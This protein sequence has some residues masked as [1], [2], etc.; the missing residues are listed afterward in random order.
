MEKYGIVNN[1]FK[2]E[3]EAGELAEACASVRENAFLCG[4]PPV[5]LPKQLKED[6]LSEM[7]DVLIMIERLQYGFGIDDNKLQQMVDKKVEKHRNR[8]DDVNNDGHLK[9]G[10]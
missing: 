2:M 4:E 5:P 6:L 1:I 10:R 9:M 8:T 7:A 3:E